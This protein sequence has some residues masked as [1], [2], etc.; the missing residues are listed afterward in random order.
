[1]MPRQP[2]QGHTD[3]RQGANSGRRLLEDERTVGA[4]FPL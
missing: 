3:R 4:I 2:A 1:M